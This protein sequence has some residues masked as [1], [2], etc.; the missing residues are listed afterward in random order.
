MSTQS[1]AREG[2]LVIVFATLHSP[3]YPQSL[4]CSDQREIMRNRE[5]ALSHSGLSRITVVLRSPFSYCALAVRRRMRNGRL[6][7]FCMISSQ[8]EWARERAKRGEPEK[9]RC[10]I[11]NRRSESLPRFVSPSS[12]TWVG[13]LDALSL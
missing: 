6:Y 9:S 5:S 13:L 1:S 10:A 8:V 11:A 7:S 3:L 2:R 4:T 12:S